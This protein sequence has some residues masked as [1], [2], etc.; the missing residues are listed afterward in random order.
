MLLYGW[1]PNTS[2]LDW[3]HLLTF[4]FFL[5]LSPCLPFKVCN[6]GVTRFLALRAMS[7]LDMSIG[8]KILS[9]I[10]KFS[11]NG[12]I[13]KISTIKKNQILK[14]KFWKNSCH[15]IIMAVQLFEAVG[16]IH[17]CGFVHLDIKPSNVLINVDPKSGE[18]NLSD[19]V[20]T[21]FGIGGQTNGLSRNG[22][23]TPGLGWT[24][25]RSTYNHHINS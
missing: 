24:Y 25:N 1:R 10:L 19:I 13:L 15:S 3:T 18:W 11:Q 6:S 5:L 21:D 16:H 7:Y 8:N 20:I 17:K 22:Y 14:T 4:Y 2:F 12:S 23:G 9:K